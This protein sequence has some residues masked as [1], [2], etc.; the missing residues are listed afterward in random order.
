MKDFSIS[1]N[2]AVES[3]EASLIL[4]QIDV[5]FDT[6]DGE[7]LG[8]NYG[9]NFY[10]FLWDLTISG[11]DISDYVKSKIASSVNLFGW[12]IDV[13]TDLLKGT[14]NDIILITIT[15]SDGYSEVEKSYKIG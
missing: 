15:L 6:L 9:T 4:Q 1:D 11:E 7:V 5:L 13:K 8:E 3:N 2:N 10:N 14:Q 12:D